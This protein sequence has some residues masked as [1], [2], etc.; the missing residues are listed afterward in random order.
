MY[1]EKREGVDYNKKIPLQAVIVKI[2]GNS[3]NLDCD[4]CFYHSENQRELYILKEKLLEKLIKEY[5]QYS[6]RKV[7][8][9]WHGGEPLLAGLSFF[10]KVIEFQEK[11]RK[12]NQIIKNAIQTNGTLID[13]KWALLFKTYNFRVGVSLDGGEETHDLFRKDY[14]RKGTFKKVVEGITILRENGIEPGIIS[15]LTKSSSN[16]LAGD[17]EYL[18][19]R[20]RIKSW[21]INVYHDDGK[22]LLNETVSNED[23][24]DYFEDTTDM[25]LMHDSSKLR[26]REIDAFGAAALN[27]TVNLCSFN[28]SCGDFI[29]V[30]V[31]GKIYPCDRYTNDNNFCIGDLNFQSLDLSLK[32][33]K[34]QEF[35]KIAKNLPLV[36]EKCQWNKFCHNGCT[37]MRNKKNHYVYCEGRRM[38]FKYFEQKIESLLERK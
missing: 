23:F 16:H 33:K 28:G 25:W 17:F 38:V 5:I 35:R 18:V 13:K 11:H 12:E 27:K 30:E 4:Y 26:I 31:D 1:R 37:S 9:I 7:Y 8:F 15:V 6:P 14:Q 3:C 24:K 2:V 10:E 21:G 36:C 20:L 22:N 32:N 34:F 29:C 19:K